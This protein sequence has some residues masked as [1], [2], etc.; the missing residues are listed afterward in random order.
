MKV[1]VLGG[2]GLIGSKLV[3]RLDERGR[4]AIPASPSSGVDTVTGEGLAEVLVN[5]EVVVDVTNA[6]A[7]DDAAVMR[8]FETSTRHI[9]AAETA[10]NVR[11]HVLLSIVGASRMGDSGYMRAKAAQERLVEAASVPFTILRSTQFFEFLGVIANVNT[12]ANTVR[13]PAA[14]VQPVAAGNVA[15]ELSEV[16][17]GAPA[18][19]AIEIAGP[20]QFRL[21]QLVSRYLSAVQDPRQVR[22]D[23][24]ARYFGAQLGAR[25]LLPGENARI[26]STGF[27][28][29]LAGRGELPR[30]S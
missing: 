10:A 15:A 8:F 21:D 4:E 23:D 26:G 24:R 30:S 22:T 29:W 19:G 13:L 14:L 2:T 12:E 6:P 11:H 16:A 20:E 28:N 9:L 3:N 5:A 27:A 1:V 25:S 7:S 18:N 17:A